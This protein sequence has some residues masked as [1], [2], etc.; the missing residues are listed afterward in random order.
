MSKYLPYRGFEWEDPENFNEEKIK[1]MK[2]DQ[3][4]GYLFEVDLTYPKEL[5]D[6]HSDLPYCPENVIN[7][8]Q[9]PKLFTTLY[10]KKN[11]VLHYLNLKQ[12]LE[13]GLKLEKIQNLIN[14]IE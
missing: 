11:Y 9:L 10:D 12:A 2:D 3:K 14:L 4:I 1:N 7:D 8:S 6:K 5:H 13:A